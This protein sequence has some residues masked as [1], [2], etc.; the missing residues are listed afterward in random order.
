MPIDRIGQKRD[1]KGKR[2]LLRPIICICNDQNA[3]SLAKLRPHARQ[4]RFSRPADLLVVKRLRE[5]CELE[6]LK[7]DSRAL[8]TL[9]G[10]ARGDLRGCLNAL[11]VCICVE[12]VNSDLTTNNLFQ[13]IKAR[14]GEVTEPII[15]AATAGMKEAESSNLSVLNSLFAPM[16]RKR[17]KELG[18]GEKDEARYVARLSREIDS[19]NN[20]STIATG[21]STSTY[22]Y[23]HVLDH[24]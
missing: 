15:R 3:H 16:A 19:V 17:V 13:F 21:R 23:V 7:A 10:V 2:P 12:R 22:T 11:Q 4:I 18:L 14:S 24:S 9:V 5:V 20:S 8:S 6:G 1:H